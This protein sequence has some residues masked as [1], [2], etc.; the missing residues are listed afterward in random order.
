MAFKLF[1]VISCQNVLNQN[2]GLLVIAKMKHGLHNKARSECNCR[3]RFEHLSFLHHFFLSAVAELDDM[4]QLQCFGIMGLKM[5]CCTHVLRALAMSGSMVP[6]S[7]EAAMCIWTDTCE[8]LITQ[9]TFELTICHKK[10]NTWQSVWCTA[11][12]LCCCEPQ[13]FCN[14]THTEEHQENDTEV[15]Q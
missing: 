2:Q 9:S 15:F 6:L 3:E 10:Q 4:A 5:C 8:L 13:N 7:N 1:H 11:T 14:V 12:V